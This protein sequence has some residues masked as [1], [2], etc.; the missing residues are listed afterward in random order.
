MRRS[1]GARGKSLPSLLRFA[2]RAGVSPHA[3]L[4]AAGVDPALVGNPDAEIPHGPKLRLWDEAAHL[5]GD[6]DFGLHLAEWVCLSPEEHFA[7]LTFAVQSCATLGEHYK[8]MERYV[9]LIHEGTFLT[10]EV[11]QD[12][13]RLSH[14]VIDG[15]LPPRQPVE[16]MLALAVLQGRRAVGDDF[17]PREVRFAHTSPTRVSEQERLFRAPVRYAWPRNEL[18]LAR[19]DLERPQR[20]AEPRLLDVLDG[21]IQALLSWQSETR[22]LPGRVTRYMADQL[23]DGEPTLSSV[24]AKL[25]MSSRSLQRRLQ[26]EGTTFA[27]LLADL[28]RDL[29]SRY[30]SNAGTTIAEVA[31]LL[32]FTEISAFHRA[33]KRWTGTTPAEYK[34]IAGTFPRPHPS[35]CVNELADGSEH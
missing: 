19:A 33:F 4:R 5:T 26:D 22:S 11:E 29:A 2:A 24:A 3:L 32:G 1:E 9:R 7:V 34:R 27:R 13:A 31:F 20:H 28:R 8:R 35:A 15:V 10:L 12:D 14:G 6:P 30:L 16:C 18:V 25:K 21:Q 23:P 17:S